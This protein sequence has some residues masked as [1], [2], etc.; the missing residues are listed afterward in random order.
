MF[1]GAIRIIV[2]IIVKIVFFVAEILQYFKFSKW[3]PTP[4]WIFEIVNFI[5]YWIGE[6]R[7][8]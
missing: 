8:A 3:P 2:P 6:G 5:G 1:G 7:G 4:S